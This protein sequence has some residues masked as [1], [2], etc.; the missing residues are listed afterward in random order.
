MRRGRRRRRLGFRNPEAQRIRIEYK[1]YFTSEYIYLRRNEE[2][3]SLKK[4]GHE[5]KNVHR[6]M[7]LLRI[8]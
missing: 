6:S 3:V 1:H 2:C 7:I 5:I 8:R 4:K